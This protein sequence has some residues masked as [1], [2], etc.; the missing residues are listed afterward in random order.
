MCVAGR[1]ALSL[2][3]PSP[4]SIARAS[5]GSLSILD[6]ITTRRRHPLSLTRARR[7]PLSRHARAIALAV[8]CV[9]NHFLDAGAAAAAASASAAARASAMTPNFTLGEWPPL[10]VPVRVYADME[11]LEEACAFPFSRPHPADARRLGGDDD[12]LRGVHD[13]GGGGGGEADDGGAAGSGL[14]LGG[15]DGEGGLGLG[16]LGGLGDDARGG[17]GGGLGQGEHG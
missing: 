15:A 11:A 1:C 7:R 17:D 2:L 14:L 10:A 5:L 9:S 3:S 16:G 13:G 6:F 12:G 4:S 8:D